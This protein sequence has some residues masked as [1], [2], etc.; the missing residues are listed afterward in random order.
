MKLPLLTRAEHTEPSKPD[1]IQFYMCLTQRLRERI[2]TCYDDLRNTSLSEQ[3]LD[4]FPSALSLVET[5][6]V[7][8]KLQA[9]LLF[10]TESA[11][12]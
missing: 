3:N 8:V 2:L 4:I 1:H 7:D 5:K 11:K 6:R 10:T 12:T 9:L